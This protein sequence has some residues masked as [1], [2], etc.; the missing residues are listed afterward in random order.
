[1]IGVWFLIPRL[2]KVYLLTSNPHNEYKLYITYM[3]K[4]FNLDISIM[5]CCLLK[6]YDFIPPLNVHCSFVVIWSWHYNY[7]V[8]PNPI[9]SLSRFRFLVCMQKPC[10]KFWEETISIIL[11]CIQYLKESQMYFSLKHIII[12]WHYLTL[13]HQQMDYKI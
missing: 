6:C 9:A 7:I 3:F 11:N 2:K 13:T 1:M 10:D 8:Y 4:L 5:C 12:N